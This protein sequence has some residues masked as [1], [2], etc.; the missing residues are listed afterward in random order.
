MKTKILK[1]SEI[2]IAAE[3]LKQ[4]EVVAFPT[5][6]VFGLGVIFDDVVAYQKLVEAKQR[7]PKQPFT[8]MLAFERDIEQYIHVN[9]K[10]IK[11]IKNF[12]PG[13]LTIIAPIKKKLT[14]DITLG[15][16]Y[17]GIRVSDSVLV[18]NLI[19]LVGKPLLVP[20]ANIHGEAVCVNS[21]EVLKVFNGKISAVIEVASLSQIPST[22][23]KVD[24]KIEL[25][26][27][28]TNPFKD[29]LKVS[30]GNI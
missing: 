23:I 18:S 29:I 15:T 26:R 9:E 25:I 20:S 5:E 19:S 6:T 27:E 4:G 22:I 30:E 2:N 3:L 8:M 14:H 7:P 12:M 1:Q 11:I 17:I 28:G 13:P 16:G 21:S 10:I 24:D